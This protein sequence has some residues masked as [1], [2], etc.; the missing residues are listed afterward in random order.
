M[1]HDDGVAQPD[2]PQRVPHDRAVDVTVAY[3]VCAAQA[4]VTALRVDVGPLGGEILQRRQRPHVEL[5]LRARHD[6]PM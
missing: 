4:L 1:R 6:D 3:V 2:G 5:D